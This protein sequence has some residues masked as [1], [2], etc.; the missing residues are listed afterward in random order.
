MQ[1]ILDFLSSFTGL[2][3]EQWVGLIAMAAIGLAFFC[4]WVIHNIVTHERRK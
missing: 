4:I 3:S 2:P 1:A